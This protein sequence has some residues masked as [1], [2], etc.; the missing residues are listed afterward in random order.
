MA[1]KQ[2][3]KCKENVQEDAK[4]CKHCKADLRNWFLRHKII[5][6][7]LILFTIGIIGSALGDTNKQNTNSDTRT[8][9]TE[10]VVEDATTEE[11]EL[12]TVTAKALTDEYIQNEIAADEKYKNETIEVSGTIQGIGKD[13]LD[14][15]YV[16]LKTNDLITSVQCML[17]DSEST[18]AANLNKNQSITL[19]GEVSG[20]MMNVLLNDCVILD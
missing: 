15:M 18:K 14:D 16:T 4:K 10:S 13:L 2:C 12:I 20:K 6:G 8:N 7:I 1:I 3:S 5:T 17:D 19:R 11:V 9:K